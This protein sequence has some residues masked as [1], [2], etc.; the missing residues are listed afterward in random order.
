MIDYAIR[1]PEAAALRSIKT[2]RMFSGVGEPDE[3]LAD[4]NLLL[5]S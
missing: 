2:E 1:N 4:P 3:M 5:R